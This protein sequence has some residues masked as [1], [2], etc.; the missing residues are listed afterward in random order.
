M[1]VLCI[2][3]DFVQARNLP[4]FERIIKFPKTL[5]EYNIREVVN[6]SGRDGYLLEEIFGG[7]LANGNEVSFNQNRFIPLEALDVL[8][9][10]E[11]ING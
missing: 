2:N 8:E 4:G 10:E 1:R 9:L 6:R 7:I 3:G 5:E 11:S